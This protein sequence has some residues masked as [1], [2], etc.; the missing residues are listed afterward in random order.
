[1]QCMKLKSF[2]IIVTDSLSYIVF[3]SYI[4]LILLVSCRDTFTCHQ[5]V[6]IS[7]PCSY[8]VTEFLILSPFGQIHSPV[9]YL[10]M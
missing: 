6:C 4:F 10:Y 1:M 8:Y 5:I 2:M 9:T 3:C 7:T